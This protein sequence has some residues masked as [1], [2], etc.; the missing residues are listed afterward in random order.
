MLH[1]LQKTK[2]LIMEGDV[3]I[4]IRLPKDVN[5]KL[6]I[7][8]SKL[9]RIGVKRTKHDEILRLMLIGLIQEI[10]NLK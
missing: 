2:L 7:F 1:L 5:Y 3:N 4:R 8:R 10:K 9:K 6:S